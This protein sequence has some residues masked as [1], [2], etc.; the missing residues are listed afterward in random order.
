M[1][2]HEMFLTDTGYLWEGP[3]EGARTQDRARLFGKPK[4]G[5]EIPSAAVR[6][7]L[8]R[9]HSGLSL[10]STASK[11]KVRNRRGTVSTSRKSR[12]LIFRI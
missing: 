8:D 11:S 7:A 12:I 9:Q 4:L 5:F 1:L 6:S 2:D 3:F 10:K